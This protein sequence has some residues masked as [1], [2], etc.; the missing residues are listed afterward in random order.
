[1]ACVELPAAQAAVAELSWPVLT[2]GG[3]YPR[4]PRD[5]QFPKPFSSEIARLLLIFVFDLAV[6]TRLLLPLALSWLKLNTDFVHNA[7]T[8]HWAGRWNL[9]SGFNHIS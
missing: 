2:M 6:F 9:T 5:L 4:A 1:M 8:G 7:E 3:N